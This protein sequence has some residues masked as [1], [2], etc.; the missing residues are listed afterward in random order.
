MT[1]RD[2]KDT[3]GWAAEKLVHAVLVRYELARVIHNSMADADDPTI[4]ISM[5]GQEIRI[6][7]PDFEVSMPRGLLS[8]RFQ[9]HTYFV[10]VKQKTYFGYYEHWEEPTTGIDNSRLENYYQFAEEHEREVR[11]WFVHTFHRCE[12]PDRTLFAHRDGVPGIY[13]ADVRTLY[14]RRFVWQGMAYW[15]I[16]GD[17]FAFTNSMA[18]LRE[19]PDT[20]QW[21]AA[22][23][24]YAERDATIKPY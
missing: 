16:R 2:R 10:E 19:A 18:E 7:L 22:L 13:E 5:H 12:R 21:A 14:H 24:T 3:K 15:C 11:L 1:T 17:T 6:P 23:R 20:K 8:G 4:G 9:P